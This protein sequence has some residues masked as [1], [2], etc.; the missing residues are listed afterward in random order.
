MATLDVSV[1]QVEKALRRLPAGRLKEAL[2]FIEFLEY[3]GD[4]E[5]DDS[6]DADLWQA[7][8][9]HQAYRESHPEE[10]PEVFDSPQAFLQATA[11]L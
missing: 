2:L 8:L 6:E 11:N 1:E 7:V 5:E 3:L 10:L 4:G 9:A